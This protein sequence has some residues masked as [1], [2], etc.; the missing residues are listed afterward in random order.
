MPPPAVP[1]SLERTWRGELSTQA[2]LGRVLTDLLREA[3]D[4]AARVVTVSPDVASSTNAGG[5]INK[6][7]VWAPADRHDWFAATEGQPDDRLVRWRE[8][9]TGQHLALGIAEVNLVGLLGELGATWTTSGQPLLPIGTV[10]DPFVTRALEPW[11][12]GTYA[13]GQSVLVGTPSGVT[14]APEGGAHQSITTPSIGIETPGLTAYEP[15]FAQ[16][17]EW[18]LLDALSR[19]GRPDGESAYLRLTT[20]PLDQALSALPTDAAGLEQRRRDVL[21]GGYRLRATEEPDVLLAVVG[22]LVPEALAAADLLAG[23]GVRADVAV[24]TSADRLW[25]A[26][27]ARRGLLRGSPHGVDETVLDRLLPAGVPLVTLLDGA[28]HTL[29]FL[30]TVTRVATTCLGVQEL[31]QAGSL[32][33]VHRHHGLDARAVVEAALDLVDV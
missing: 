16:E 32:A 33:D 18:C 13:G 2:A 10:Y 19:L 1:P 23:L 21:A 17:L 14:L 8:T 20:R 28:P 24:V 29:A 6:V 12:F 9:S 31:G 5:W 4:V 25:R 26:V 11:V 22:A 27:Q 30:G 15:A 7:G 3:P